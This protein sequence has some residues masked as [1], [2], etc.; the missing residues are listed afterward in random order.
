MKML[1][2]TFSECSTELAMHGTR[3]HSIHD[4]VFLCRA[5]EQRR[6]RDLTTAIWIFGVFSGEL[7]QYLCVNSTKLKGCRTKAEQIYI[8]KKYIKQ[9]NII[10]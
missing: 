6:L 8:F 5:C 9:T 3:C 7:A 10:G 4:F 1:N 2:V